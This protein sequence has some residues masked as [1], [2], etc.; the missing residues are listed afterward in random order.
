MLSKTK[1]KKMTNQIKELQE[2]LK[3]VEI[4]N[5]ELQISVNQNTAEIKNV[6]DTVSKTIKIER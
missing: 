5:A 3:S 4:K 6:S 1:A 2:R